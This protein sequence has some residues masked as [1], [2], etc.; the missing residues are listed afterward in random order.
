MKHPIAALAAAIALATAPAARAALVEY[1][2]VAGIRTFQDTLTGTVW[3]DL[4]NH[5]VFTGTGFAFRYTD[6]AD[7]LAALQA[8]G[9][10]WAT[11]AEVQALTGTVPLT[12]SMD[13]AAVGSV[14]GSL[15]FGETGT[16]DG[17]ADAGGSQAQRQYATLSGAWG[18][19][20]VGALPAALN[21]AGLWAYVAVPGGV[22]NVPE[23]ASLA[24]VGLALAAL[25]MSRP[26]R[27]P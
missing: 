10:T 5:L 21:D 25:G 6:R 8:A 19:G 18:Q 20:G 26:R 9:F 4:D 13:F 14:V 17:Y 15:S 22:G 3:A 12:G 2:D 16:I 1:A 24:L 7:H 27:R 23:P 11:V